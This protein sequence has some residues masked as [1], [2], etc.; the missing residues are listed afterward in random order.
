M[1]KSWNL[2]PVSR[3]TSTL[4]CFRTGDLQKRGEAAHRGRVLNGSQLKR[5]YIESC[6]SNIRHRSQ[7]TG[8]S[9]IYNVSQIELHVQTRIGTGIAVRTT[10]WTVPTCLLPLSLALVLLYFLSPRLQAIVQ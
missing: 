10:H 2:A 4:T 8:Y 9:L 3:E 5:A 7:Q 1:G 6:V